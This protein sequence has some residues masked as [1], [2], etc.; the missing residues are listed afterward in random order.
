MVS[1]NENAADAPLEASEGNK[2]SINFPGAPALEAI[3][4]N[5]NFANQVVME[6]ENAKF[7]MPH[8]NPFY[9][10]SEETEP[11]AAKALD[12]DDDP[13]HLILRTQIDAVDKNNIS[14][15]DQ[16]LNIKALNEFDHNAQGR[17]GRTGMANQINRPKRCSA[18]MKNNSCKL[19]RWIV[20]SILAK[21]DVMK[22]G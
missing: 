9:N 10:P 18:E 13:L 15:D 19:A 4:I 14:G 22:L 3:S 16:F 6:S 5:H 11:L 2:D 20:Q 1:V 8:E 21:A 12:K 17:G 7:E